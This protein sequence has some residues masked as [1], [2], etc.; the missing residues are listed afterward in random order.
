MSFL[1][2][3]FFFL[4][5]LAGTTIAIIYLANHQWS[6]NDAMLQGGQ[7]AVFSVLLI[8][9]SIATG[10]GH[11]FWG[12]AVVEGQGH[13]HNKVSRMFQWELAVM[14][15]S[16]AV[17]AMFFSTSEQ[18]P[19]AL[20]WASFLGAAGLRHLIKKEPIMTVIGDIWIAILLIGA[21]IPSL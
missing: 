20:A 10:I 8:A 21:C 15:L 4:F 9:L 5:A 11:L 3:N 13:K 19:L 18:L 16:I 12:K 1:I 14:Q 2:R 6:W 17:V 7:N